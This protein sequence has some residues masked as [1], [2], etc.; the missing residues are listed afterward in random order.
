M[1]TS[2]RRSG[3]ATIVDV[4]GDIDLHTSP[5]LSKVLLGTLRQ[6]SVS[7]VIVNLRGVK[8][9]DSSG[10][11]ALVAGLRTSMSQNGRFALC[12][13]GQAV[14]EVLAMTRLNSVFEIYDTEDKALG[15]VTS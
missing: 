2:T 11:A 7:P 13:L 9:I 6:D 8:Y 3:D 4:V 15:A 10:I 12:E 1:N 5:E 14:Q